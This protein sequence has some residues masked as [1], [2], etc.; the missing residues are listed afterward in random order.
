M[1]TKNKS[2]FVSRLS[3]LI[4]ILLTF[5]ISGYLFYQYMFIQN[6]QKSE[7]KDFGN[8]CCGGS[9]NNGCGEGYTCVK[10]ATQSCGYGVCERK[11]DMNFV[12]KNGPVNQKCKCDS[13][14]GECEDKW[15]QTN[16]KSRECKSAVSGSE[17]CNYRTRGKLYQW[18]S[19]D[20]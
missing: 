9:Q 8:V 1:K 12:L 7:A 15:G 13:D 16:I 11:S 3:K 17:I 4:V 14:F 19:C 2:F 5:L 6:S 20:E 18:V 10:G